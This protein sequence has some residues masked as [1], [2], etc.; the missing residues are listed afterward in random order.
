MSEQPCKECFLKRNLK[1]E[2]LTSE[3]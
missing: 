3:E 2:I 1:E